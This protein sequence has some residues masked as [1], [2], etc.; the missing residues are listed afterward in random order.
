WL[1]VPVALAQNE[2]TFTIR[3]SRDFGSAIGGR[4]QGQFSIRV[5]G[6][7]NLERV[8]FYIDDEQIGEDTETPFRL[9]FNT[10]SFAPGVHTFRAVGFT[11]DGQ[12]LQSNNITPT[13]MSSEE[14]RE[15]FTSSV[16]PFIIGVVVLSIAVPVVIALLT[17]QKN[18]APGTSRQY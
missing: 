17:K 2:P 16:L 5:N 11:V 10:E 4:I 13:I 9:N 3:L 1:L 8:V 15:A 18:L 6:P 7:D 12:E 14:S